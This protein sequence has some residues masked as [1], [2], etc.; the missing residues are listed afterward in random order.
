[1]KWAIQ[2]ERFDYEGF[3]CVVLMKAM[4]FR[5]GYVGIPE[6]HKLY[7]IDYN[8]IPIDCHEGLTYSNYYLTDQKD[9]DIWWIGFDTANCGDGYDFEKAKELFKDYPDTLEL[10]EQVE[11]IN[12]MVYV[13]VI[14]PKNLQYCKDECMHIVDQI[15][16]MNGEEEE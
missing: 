7:G 12:K 3:P 15:I 4:A 16:S 9:K 6:G 14:Q 10:I 2:E 8:E 5:T 11:Q 13:D 1:M